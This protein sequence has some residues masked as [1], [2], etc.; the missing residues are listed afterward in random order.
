MRP[1]RNRASSEP[2]QKQ[3]IIDDFRTAAPGLPL[4]QCGGG[5]MKECV[6]MVI[7]P[8]KLEFRKKIA[9]RY[10]DFAGYYSFHKGVEIR[11]QIFWPWQYLYIDYRKGS[12]WIDITYGFRNKSLFRE[13][14]S[15][16]Y[17]GNLVVTLRNLIMDFG[18]KDGIFRTRSLGM[19]AP[20]ALEI[21]ENHVSSKRIFHSIGIEYAEQNSEGVTIRSSGV[22]RT[23]SDNHI[24]IFDFDGNRNDITHVN[25]WRSND[26]EW[27]GFDTTEVPEGNA[28]EMYLL[29]EIP[30]NFF[31]SATYEGSSYVDYI[32][33]AGRFINCTVSKRQDGKFNIKIDGDLPVPNTI[34]PSEAHI[35]AASTTLADINL[36]PMEN[37][38]CYSGGR[39]WGILDNKLIWSNS[40]GP[41][42]H[43]RQ[44]QRDPLSIA[45]LGLG[46]IKDITSLAGN[47]YIF[48]E[49]GV[50]LI[51]ESNPDIAPQA[52]SA[53]GSTN[54]R[55]FPVDGFGIFTLTNDKLLFLDGN[56]RE[57]SQNCRGFNL[58]LL[59]DDLAKEVMDFEF[60]EGMLF[61][62]AA[63]RLFVLNLLENKGLSEFKFNS[64]V[65][66]RL[67]FA[68]GIG[69]A[70]NMFDN[71][72]AVNKIWIYGADYATESSIDYHIVLA[73]SAVHGWVE[74]WDTKV[75]AKLKP[76]SIIGTQD[77]CDG[78]EYSES[79]SMNKTD[80]LNTDSPWEYHITAGRFRDVQRPIGKTIGIKVFVDG[81]S[82]GDF[83]E[84]IKLTT[85]TQAETIRPDFNPNGMRG[86][87]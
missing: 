28:D 34:Q 47:L 1:M 51:R 24:Y 15:F 27:T 36:I 74:H 19:P 18:T 46:E 43:I 78:L 80:A 7:R 33:S 58:N 11:T 35:G 65:P 60:Y 64:L 23:L 72:E 68:N 29:F 50:S 4:S 87:S 8:G 81:A 75:Y 25:I 62:I 10:E 71:N 2:E 42:G 86:Q 73:K 22:S 39:L 3:E 12:E 38:L 69:L 82:G 21:S 40:T 76:G 32:G 84:Q 13:P 66:I 49:R 31:A 54:L 52:I 41:E 85:A 55:V 63:G 59:L 30:A 6:N 44:E 48:C 77:T 9:L 61:F 70:I 16:D 17:Y 53:I 79:L 83:I 14:F 45:D 37:A 20:K 5:V 67:E 56:T 57:Y 26:T